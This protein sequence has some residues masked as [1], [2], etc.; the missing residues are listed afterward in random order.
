MTDR[1]VGPSGVGHVGAQAGAVEG[2]VDGTLV[3]ESDVVEERPR[4]DAWDLAD[5]GDPARTQERLRVVHGGPV[6]PDRSGVVDQAGER[7]QQTGLARPDA[8]QQQD[9][10]A[11]LDGE[12]DTVDADRAVVVDGGQVVDR[13]TL[14]PI[15]DGCRRGGREAGDQVD[16]VADVH[17]VAAARQTAGLDVPRPGPRRLGDHGAGHPTEPVEPADGAGHEQRGGQAPPT[18]HVDGP[19]GDDADLD[20]HDREA[21][22]DRLHPVLTDRRSHAGVVDDAQV[23]VDGA[24]RGRQLDGADRVQGG[25]EG[26]AEPGPCRRRGGR[27][28]SGGRGTEC[29]DGG[30]GRHHGDE[31]RTGEEGSAQQRGDRRDQDAVDHVDPPVGVAGEAVGVHRPGDDLTGRCGIQAALGRLAGQHRG[32]HPQH[33]VDP[34]SGVAPDRLGQEQRRGDEA[35]DEEPESD[36]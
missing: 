26:A 6:P 18:R 11:T 9:Q 25:D 31:D 32:A 29:G 17:E 5:V 3:V 36:E 12:V 14:E 23:A 2:E 20:E 10:L 24:G 30:A 28:P 16:T 15:D 4:Q 19:G 1:R 33:D 8:T 22:E 34:P 35:G 7:G 27:R 21:V 13:Q